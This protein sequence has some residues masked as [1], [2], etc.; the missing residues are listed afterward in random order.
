MQVIQDLFLKSVFSYVILAPPHHNPFKFTWD[1]LS[2]RL[3]SY[4]PQFDRFSP[5]YNVE[6]ASILLQLSLMVSDSVAFELPFNPPS[7]LQDSDLKYD[8]CPLSLFSE[9]MPSSKYNEPTTMCHVLYNEANNLLFIVFVGT[10]N[11][12]M[13]LLDLAHEQVEYE[14]IANYV[15]GLRGHKGI[16]RMYMSI[17][18]KLLATVAQ[19][20]PRQPKIV[21]TGHSLGGGL[22]Q[23][24]ALDLAAFSPIHYGYASP[25]IFNE[26]G[27]D[28]F[29]HFVK[30]SYRIANLSDLVVLAP[31]PI[32]PN[33]DAFWHVGKLVYFQR[34]F[35]SY[36]QNH[37]LAYAQEFGLV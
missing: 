10:S 22:S 32:M 6:D 15:P 30:S 33:G 4:Q 20:L 17:R 7:W 11:Y 2:D 27:Y 14:G 35:G 31:Y 13:G 34:N 9:G 25:M 23:M 16:Y 8:C 21:I 36:M 19:Y 3:S 24:A 28:T 1:N 18:D 37:T 12:C 29:T 26:E 5:E